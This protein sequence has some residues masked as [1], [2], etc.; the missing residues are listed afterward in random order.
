MRI[1]PYITRLRDVYLLGPSIALEEGAI[2]VGL[3]LV[4]FEVGLEYESGKTYSYGC[5]RC[6]AIG[7]A[8]L[9]ELP[10]GWKKRYRRDMTYFFLCSNCETPPGGDDDKEGRES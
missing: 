4:W 9:D 10:P 3:C 6:G 2:R 8:K 1:K 7:G 5:S